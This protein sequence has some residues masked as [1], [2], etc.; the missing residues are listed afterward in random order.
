MHGLYKSE[1]IAAYGKDAVLIV[2]T[3]ALKIAIIVKCI[4]GMAVRVE[5]TDDYVIR[6]F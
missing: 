1:T 3:A 2:K 6:N 4:S 5:N